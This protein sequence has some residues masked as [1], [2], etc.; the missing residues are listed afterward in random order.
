MSKKI[1]TIGIPAYNVEKYLSECLDSVINDELEVLVINDGSTDSTEKIAREYEEKYPDIIRLINKKNGG[2]GSGVNLAIKEAK[3]KYFKNL[4]SD[5]TFDPE[6]LAALIRN[7]HETDADI[8]ISPSLSRDDKSGVVY[9][10]HMPEGTIYNKLVPAEEM[11]NAVDSV[12]WMHCMA[13]K[14]DMLQQN[15]VEIDECFYTDMEL[16]SYPLAY[17]KTTYAQP[18]SVYIYRTGRDGQSMSL[19]S[20]AKHMDD[21]ERVT[22]SMLDRFQRYD[23]SEYFKKMV[24]VSIYSYLTQPFAITDVKE[25]MRW[26]EKFKVFKKEVIDIDSDLSD[27]SKYLLPA[28]TLLKTNFKNYGAVASLWR[29]AKTKIA[30]LYHSYEQKKL[31]KGT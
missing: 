22:M 20:L 23:R 26:V 10:T 6:G 11:L 29:F 12:F 18:E 8:F 13:F 28:R 19:K 16:A 4:D 27:Y 9:S 24:L 17:A 3:G 15:N 1:L 31:R 7:M 14:T 30:P 21:R 25:Q 2:W 5:D